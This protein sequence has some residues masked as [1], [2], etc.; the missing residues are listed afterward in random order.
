M[1]GGVP[2]PAVEVQVNGVPA[3]PLAQPK[4]LVTGCAVTV[5]VVDAVA[6]ALPVLESLATLLIE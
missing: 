2:P 5:T 6:V 3:V 1:Y 4:L